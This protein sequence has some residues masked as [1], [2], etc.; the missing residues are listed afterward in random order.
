MASTLLLVPLDDTVVFPTMDVTLPVDTG[1]EDR[2]LLVPRHEGE[3]AKVGTIARVAERV[4]LPGGARGA[5]L[6][7]RGPRRGR[8]GPHRRRRAACASRS[9]EHAD[10]AGSPPAT[11]DARARV[12]RHGRGD[13]RAPRRR[14][15]HR[16]LA[17]RD[18]RARR[19]GRHLGLRARPDL[20][21]EGPPAG[22]PRRRGPPRAG[23]RA[24]ARA[25]G[26]AAGAQAHPRGRRGG[27]PEAAARVRAAQ[28]DGV[29]PPRARRGRRQRLRRP[30]ARRSRRPAC[31]RPCAS[32]PSASSPASSAPASRA[33][34]R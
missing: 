5:V 32:R 16:R 10:E 28:A 18:Q 34:A 24:P 25:P 19:A 3:Y 14:R 17:A 8:R 33:R 31:R 11:R 29:D 22:D 27:R 15:P 4:R 6:A 12:P 1:D 7:G 20:R 9:I 2:V 23:A 21:A 13:P 30:S 26:R